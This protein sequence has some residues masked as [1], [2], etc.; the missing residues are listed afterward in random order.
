MRPYSALFIISAWA[1]FVLTVRP[2]FALGPPEASAPAA[3][4]EYYLSYPGILP[5]H[6]LYK[7]KVA[8]ERI[9]A[10][11]I[12][13]PQE[14]VNFYLKQADKGILATAML[15]DKHNSK[16]AQTTALK[17]EHNMTLL[18]LELSNFEELPDQPLLDKLTTASLKHQ[19][20]LTSLLG[21]IPQNEH[22]VFQQVIDFSKRNLDQINSYRLTNLNDKQ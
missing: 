13:D 7:L 5:D 21:R 6:P 1:L 20:V 11:F 16:L 22:A 12:S 19:E 2:V 4:V 18:S 15:V 8:R 9:I 14:K 17:A 10:Y 3:P